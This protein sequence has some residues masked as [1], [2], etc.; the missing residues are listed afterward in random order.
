[1]QKPRQQKVLQGECF[2]FHE[3]EAIPSC[4]RVLTRLVMF[5]ALLVLAT[6]D[7]DY[8]ARE[9]VI[10]SED[11]FLPW[12]IFLGEVYN[13]TQKSTDQKVLIRKIRFG[14]KNIHTQVK[15][16]KFD[17][18]APQQ[19]IRGP[20]SFKKLCSELQNCLPSS[21]F[22]LFHDIKSKCSGIDNTCSENVTG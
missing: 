1:M 13:I 7:L 11:F 21:S 19:R 5:C 16:I 4:D 6:L 3:E 8:K 12:K 20:E 22:F 14:K 18:S 17:L 2:T 10:M 9:S 15:T